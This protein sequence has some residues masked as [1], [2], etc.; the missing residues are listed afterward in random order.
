MPKIDQ[1]AISQILGSEIVDPKDLTPKE[2]AMVSVNPIPAQRILPPIEVDCADWV[3]EAYNQVTL[4]PEQAESLKDS[5]K[6]DAPKTSGVVSKK[7]NQCSPLEQSDT[8]RQ[9]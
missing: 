6:A 8:A 9:P 7:I 2:K 1:K 4:T 5:S 3:P